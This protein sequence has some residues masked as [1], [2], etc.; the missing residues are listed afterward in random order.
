[1]LCALTSS[2]LDDKPV[3]ERVETQVENSSFLTTTNHTCCYSIMPVIMPTSTRVVIYF[4]LLTEQLLQP[5]CDGVS[6]NLMVS[7]A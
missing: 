1:M 3:N 5:N 2:S 7:S 6:W 4:Y